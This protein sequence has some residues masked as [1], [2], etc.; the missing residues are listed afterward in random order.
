MSHFVQA[1]STIS[2]P[3]I[4]EPAVL[5]NPKLRRALWYREGR[6]NYQQGTALAGQMASC[7]WTRDKKLKVPVKKAYGIFAD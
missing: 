6:R 3:H 2:D 4:S 1:T 5:T 7:A